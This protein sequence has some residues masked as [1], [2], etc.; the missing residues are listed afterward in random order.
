MREWI[1]HDS[2]D[3]A[4]REPF[5]AVS[6][7][8]KILIRIKVEGANVQSVQL[9]LWQEENSIKKEINMKFVHKR[10]KETTYETEITAPS[11]PTLLWYYF[12]ITCSSKTYYYGN[13]PNGY[14]GK[15][16]ITEHIPRAYQVT[17][18]HHKLKPPHWFK[19]AI[20]YQIFVDR[21]ANGNEDGK[22]LH[23][24][25]NSLIH[26][27]W[28]NDPYYIRDHEG[29]IVYW[30]FFGGNLLGIK[31]KLA[32]LKQLGVNV[33]YLNPVFEAAS[34]HKYDTGDY[35]KIDPMFGDNDLFQ[36]LVEEGKKQGV[37]FILD[38][39]FSHTGSD[40]IYFNKEGNYDSI[41]AYQSKDSPYYAWYRFTKYPDAYESWW[42]IDVLPNVNELEP[43]YQNFIIFDENSVLHY[44]LNKGIK[45]W[46]LDVADEL[47]DQFIRCFNKMMKKKDP[48][49]VLIGE[50]W[51]DASNKI[52]YG[53]RRK[54]VTDDELDSV[55]NYPFR[56]AVIDFLLENKNAE[57]IHRIFM[58]LYENYPLS[59]FYSTMNL[60]GS[61]DT[62]RILSVLQEDINYLT[63]TERKVIGTN[64]VKLA[65]L[66]QMTFPGV[67]SIYYGDEAGLEGVEEPLNRRTY[68]WGRENQ[69]LLNW[70]RKITVLRAKYD[71][72]KTGTWHSFFITEDIYGFVR[73]INDGKDIFGQKKQNNV[74]VVL[75]NRHLEKEVF[76]HLDIRKWTSI[77]QL[78]D[79][80][81][82]EE[83]ITAEYNGSFYLS[84]QP[85]E[86]K[87]LLHR[88]ND[89]AAYH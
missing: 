77:D 68:P 37:F 14:G 83:I 86:G 27:H 56:N 82:Q 8:Q 23:P 29:K 15:G 42:G 67:P 9:H 21:F 18:F 19:E 28:E 7:K 17:V 33:I 61:H 52:S 89:E 80:L 84:L 59:H 62:P 46:R 49:A 1:V 74:A 34:N 60:L 13:H 73:T 3:L 88:L 50:V 47:P 65:V 12:K 53:V 4:Y 66:W 75:I 55:M 71:V 64:R 35:H 57:E 44:W 43:S 79:V 24:K 38:G 22:I 5:G 36:A 6:C 45:G 72:L 39:V 32:Y 10:N 58:S 20:M 40:S 25:K 76:F 87:I 69:D 78:I 85:L 41:G 63:E 26:A 54:Y 16:V 48:E 30:D 11:V 2:H 81:N 51:E 31:K 70:Y